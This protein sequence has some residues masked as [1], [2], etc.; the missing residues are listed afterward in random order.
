METIYRAE[1]INE[2]SIA[3]G[4]ASVSIQRP[5]RMARSGQFL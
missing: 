2:I 5:S 1:E 4:A 3:I